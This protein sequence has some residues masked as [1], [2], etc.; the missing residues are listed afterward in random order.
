MEP[1]A[2]LPTLSGGLLH[3]FGQSVVLDNAVAVDS[4]DTRSDDIFKSGGS[5]WASGVEVFLQRRTGALTWLG[6]LYPGLDAAHLP[7]TEREGL[8]PQV[9]P[10]PRPVFRSL[11]PSGKMASWLKPRVRHRAGL[12]PGLGPLF[13][14]RANHWISKDYVLPAERN[15]A[16]LLPYHRLD[17]SASREFGLWGLDVEFYLQFSISIAGATS[18]SCSTIPTIPRPIQR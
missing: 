13:A 2:A 4:E 5:G 6:G 11:V 18:G 14:A 7:R 1:V 8:S 10:P 3:R 15:S 9:R 17:A 12:H 16:R